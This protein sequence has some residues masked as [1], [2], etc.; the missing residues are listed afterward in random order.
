MSYSRKAR[1]LEQENRQL[2]RA[3]REV[4]LALARAQAKQDFSPQA[5]AAAL[6][7]LSG[8]KVQ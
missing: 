6:A 7:V 1:K 8:E 5:A 2:K 3:L 4:L